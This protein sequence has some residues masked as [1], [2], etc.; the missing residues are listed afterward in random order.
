MDGIQII[1]WIRQLDSNWAIT[2]A[3]ALIMAEAGRLG[4]PL[5]D[6]SMSGRSNVRDQGID[7][8]TFFPEGNSPFPTGHCVWQVKSGPTHPSASDEFDSR[9]TGLLDALREG[10]DYVLFWSFDPTDPVETAVRND[11][12]AAA[13]A[14]RPDCDVQF[15]FAD[16]IERL[17]LLHPATLA[18]VPNL[19]LRGVVDL[20][21][22]GA[23]FQAAFV[24]DDRRVQFKEVLQAHV[25]SED[26]HNHSIHIFGDSGVGKSRLVYES[27]SVEGILQRVLVAR[28]PAD[29]DRTLLTSVA[30]R[31]ESRLVLIV[32]DCSPEQVEALRG[33]AGMAG[34]RVR[35]ITIGARQDRAQVAGDI[36]YLEVLP[37]AAAAS[38]EI[39]LSVGVGEEAAELVA[40]FT[41]GYPRLA[42]LL[43]QAVVYSSPSAQLVQHVR[44]HEVSPILSAMLPDETDQ[45]A[46]ALLALFEKLGFERELSAETETVCSVFGIPETQFRRIVDRELGR[47]VS[48]AGR[49]RSVT[50]RLFAIWLAQKFID[51]RSEEIPGLIQQLPENLTDS[52]LKQM[53]AFADE[54][55]VSQVL[56]G[57]LGRSPFVQGALDEINEGAARFLHATA[58]VDPTLA[59]S[60]I[61]GLL[62]GRSLDEIQ[63]FGSGRR[64]VVWALELLLWFAD[65]FDAAAT[66][67]L[68]LAAAENESWAN[69]ATGVLVGI[70]RVHLGGTSRPYS[71]RIRW[72][73]DNLDR[74]GERSVSII[75]DGLGQAL[76]THESRTS[77]H[78][79]SRHAPEEWRPT[80]TDEEVLARR[81][82][83]D[84]LVDIFDSYPAARDRVAS[85]LSK[86]VRAAIRRGLAGHLLDVLE[87]REFSTSARTLL[88]TAIARTLEYDSVSPELARRLMQLKDRLTGADLTQRLS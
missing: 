83:L 57:I 61:R 78:F 11:F 76:Q 69:N 40:D 72:A 75:V 60:A 73:R 2:L 81:L 65:T 87:R 74:W 68:D 59:A 48:R 41:E 67:L 47:Y 62:D 86:S 54:P 22:W 19:P 50:P 31:A 20:N 63:D 43:A 6:F 23:E 66:S 39:A 25:G 3:K 33:Y 18:Y 9:H 24:D 37:L 16:R 1:Q 51:A 30:Q 77:P 52:F 84:L 55:L 34:G 80:T 46:L 53:E 88:G 36:R 35:L 64:H 10:H 49:Y 45:Q 79:G 8:R 26:A 85:V 17:A 29:F 13:R 38:R 44:G 7:G 56:G 70:F 27:M 12:R 4:L 21:T 5:S 28:D 82:A 71:D 42:L 32:D 15:L 58:L 14:I